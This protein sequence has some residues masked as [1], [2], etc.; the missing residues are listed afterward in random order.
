MCKIVCSPPHISLDPINCFFPVVFSANVPSLL[1]LDPL[2]KVVVPHDEVLVRA[3]FAH[4]PPGET[5][6]PFEEEKLL[7]VSGEKVVA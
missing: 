7:L 2:H 3:L 6:K 1:L 5:P 4:R